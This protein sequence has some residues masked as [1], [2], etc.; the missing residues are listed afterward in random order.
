MLYHLISG[1]ISIAVAAVAAVLWWRVARLDR[2]LLRMAIWP[3]SWLV[4]VVA[5]QLCVVIDL[6]VFDLIAPQGLNYWAS[7]LILHALGVLLYG[8]RVMYLAFRYRR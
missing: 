6:Y 4:N 1:L 7:G 8:A 5:F 2:S 3:L